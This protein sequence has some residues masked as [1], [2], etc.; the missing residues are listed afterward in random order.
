VNF[1]FSEEQR[2][3]YDEVSDYVRQEL[4]AN[5][6]ER[7]LFW[8]GAYGTLPVSELEFQDVLQPFNKK[9]GQKG[10]LTLGWPREYFGENSMMK[11]AIVD[12]ITTYY[13]AP[14]GN[15][16]SAIIGPTLIAVGSEEMKNEWLPRIARGE[17]IFW[18]GYSEP[19]AGSDLGSIG[20]T[21]RRDGDDF[22]ISGQK[23]WSSAAHFADYGWVLARTDPKTTSKYSG[24]TLFIVPNDSPGITIRPIENMCGIHSFNEVFFD[25]VRV[26]AKNIAGQL[27]HGF[28]HIMLTLQLER[29]QVGIGAFRRVLGE[30]VAYVRETKVNGR[31]LSK[32]TL[33]RNKLA[34][35]AIEIEILYWYYWRSAWMMDKGLSPE[36]ESSAVKLYG[37]ELSRRLANVSM[38]ILGLSG[39]L[40][41]GS[42]WAP[43]RGRISLGYLDSISGPIG[44]GTSE[45]MRTMVAT[46]G[47]GLPKG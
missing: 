31:L 3:F 23:V 44:A 19:N 7:A 35:L 8:P 13:R 18:L 20:T 21:A 30:L 27:N 38:D 25:D 6:D 24:A 47:L 4:P 45:I 22:L 11:A 2:A 37:T 41:R 39:Q 40:V 46:R 14:A 16:A 1:E 29:R 9:L 42:K 26:P 36:L 34:A 43:L 10:W 33:V 28:Y 15:L 12:D 17:A 5:W 32:D